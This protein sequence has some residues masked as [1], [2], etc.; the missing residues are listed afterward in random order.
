MWALDPFPL[1]RLSRPAQQPEY[2]FLYLIYSNYILH[3]YRVFTAYLIKNYNIPNLKD[4]E[5]LKLCS[6]EFKHNC[7]N[8]LSC[9]INEI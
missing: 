3:E 9:E 5:K 7:I 8:F 1:H 2:V 6:L 4:L